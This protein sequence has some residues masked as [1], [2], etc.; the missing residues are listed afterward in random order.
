MY[1][2]DMKRAHIHFH[3]KI[4]HTMT[5]MNVNINKDSTIAGSVIPKK[6]E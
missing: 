3:S 5:K 2:Q 1:K 6:V 4:P